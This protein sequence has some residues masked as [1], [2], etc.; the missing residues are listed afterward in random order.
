MDVPGAAPRGRPGRKEALKVDN[1]RRTGMDAFD[2]AQDALLFKAQLWNRIR[3]QMATPSVQE[4]ED[5]DLEWVS[6]AGMPVNPDDKPGS[7]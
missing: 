6:A 3:S 4:L 5:D 7:L 2:F 1:A